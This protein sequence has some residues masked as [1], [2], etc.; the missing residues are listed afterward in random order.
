MRCLLLPCTLLLAGVSIASAQDSPGYHAPDSGSRTFIAGVDV[1]PTPGLPFTASEAITWTRPT[2]GAGNITAHLEAKIMRDSDGRAYRERHAFGSPNSDPESTLQQFYVMDPVAHTVTTCIKAQ[3]LCHMVLLGT[4]RA[5]PVPPVGPFNNG[6][7]Y[8]ARTPLGSQSQ[9]DLR[10]T[11]TVETV[12]I[13]AGTF[14]NDQ[15]MTLTREFWYSPDLQINLSVVRKD[16]RTGTQE[17]RVTL[18]SRS[19]PDPAALKIPA[20]YRVIDNRPA[21][22]R[23]GPPETAH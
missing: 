17:I 23:I 10:V 4:R 13:Q 1:E 15:T 2:D 16:P 8:L 6:K 19:D 3:R 9:Q 18:N 11:G 22:L 7:E 12:T 21:P 14:G 20:G 5:P